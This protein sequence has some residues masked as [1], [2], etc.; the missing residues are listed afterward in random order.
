MYPNRDPYNNTKLT[1]IH[2]NLTLILLPMY[3]HLGTMDVITISI[4]LSKKT[5][6]I[7]LLLNTFPPSPSP[8]P[9]T[10]TAAITLLF[11]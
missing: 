11:L 3:S 4:L 10:A 5:R 2:L 9:T 8:P 6:R 7:G 1:R